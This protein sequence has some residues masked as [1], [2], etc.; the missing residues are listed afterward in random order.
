MSGLMNEKSRLSFF[1]AV[2]HTDEPTVNASMRTIQRALNRAELAPVAIRV[3]AG[4]K[5]F[6]E[7]INSALDQGIMSGADFLIH[8]ASDV[9]LQEN[10][11]EQLLRGFSPH[12]NFVSIAKGYDAIHGNFSSGGLWMFDLRV[13]GGKF[14]FKN[15]FLADMKFSA[16]VEASTGLSRAYSADMLTYHHPIWTPFELFSKFR[17]SYTKYGTNPYPKSRMMG[18]LAKA[19]ESNPQNLAIVAGIRGLEFGIRSTPT[20]SKSSTS[21][22]ED[23]EAACGDLRLSGDEYFV[24]H[25]PFVVLARALLDSNQNC[26]TEPWPVGLEVPNWR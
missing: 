26:V 21:M 3:I 5:S 25:K 22:R 19:L 24:I 13:L 16:R 4:K 11:I 20:E 6:S 9:F 17:Y 12:R 2:S 14:R 10:A 15:E 1:L 7:S 8:T 23:F 18:F